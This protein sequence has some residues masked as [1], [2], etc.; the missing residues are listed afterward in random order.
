MCF[1]EPRGGAREKVLHPL[2][3]KSFAT[4]FVERRRVV[5]RACRVKLLLPREGFDERTVMQ[6]VIVKLEELPHR[7]RHHHEATENSGK[8][9]REVRVLDHPKVD[10]R[11]RGA[12]QERG[13]LHRIEEPLIPSRFFLVPLFLRLEPP[14]QVFE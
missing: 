2:H 5:A 1:D 9:S 3:Q 12:G 11:N 14:F 8:H 6:P 4:G 10:D 13:H 7:G